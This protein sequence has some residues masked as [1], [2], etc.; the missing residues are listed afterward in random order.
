MPVRTV[1]YRDDFPALAGLGEGMLWAALATFA[2]G[3]TG[4]AVPDWTVVALAVAGYCRPAR[5]QALLP[6][7][8]A[9]ACSFLSGASVPSLLIPYAAALAVTHLAMRREG[10]RWSIDHLAFA[11]VA[12]LAGAAVQLCFMGA[13]EVYLRTFLTAVALGC[14]GGPVAMMKGSQPFRPTAAPAPTLARFR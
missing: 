4:G 11:L 1:T 3:L 6:V 10:R 7:P 8:V 13:A 14:I 2:F 12:L 5:F 9:L